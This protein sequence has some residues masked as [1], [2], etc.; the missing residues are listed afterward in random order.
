MKVPYSL[1]YVTGSQKS[2]MVDA[3]P[4]MLI[5]QPVDEIET[6]FKILNPCFLRRGL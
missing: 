6:N 2:N 4:E 3:K 5:S 1:S